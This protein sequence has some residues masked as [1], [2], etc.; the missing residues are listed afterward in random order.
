VWKAG[1]ASNKNKYCFSMLS[2]YCRKIMNTIQAFLG[3][4]T[5]N[6]DR[7]LE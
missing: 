1:K 7:S 5:F 6:E 4:T 2:N 3:N